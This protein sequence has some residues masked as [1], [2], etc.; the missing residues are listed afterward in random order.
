MKLHL[1]MTSLVMRMTSRLQVRVG[2]AEV[3]LHRGMRMRSIHKHLL[4]Q[5]K[6]TERALAQTDQRRLKPFNTGLLGETCASPE[7]LPYMVRIKWIKRI[8][9]GS[10]LDQDP[11]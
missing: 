6:G 4:E 11:S 7:L 9:L 3:S 10:C 5:G 2:V 1:M 8:K